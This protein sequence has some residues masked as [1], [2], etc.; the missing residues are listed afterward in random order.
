MDHA[1]SAVL[2]KL[3]L[4]A[5]NEEGPQAFGRQADVKLAVWPAA[6]QGGYGKQGSGGQP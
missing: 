3:G 1:M 5:L 6:S 4:D 2:S